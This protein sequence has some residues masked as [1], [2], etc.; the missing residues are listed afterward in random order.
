MGRGVKTVSTKGVNAA[1]EIQGKPVIVMRLRGRV[2]EKP[3]Q[4]DNTEQTRFMVP[5]S[6]LLLIIQSLHGFEWP[7]P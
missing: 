1:L 4:D 2:T 3:R 6:Q 7:R 5:P